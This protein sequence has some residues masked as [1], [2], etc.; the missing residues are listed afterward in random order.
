MLQEE[1]AKVEAAERQAGDRQK[2]G[3]L[4]DSFCER[5]TQ[6]AEDK[7]RCLLCRK[8]FRGPEFVHKHIREKHRDELQAYLASPPPQTSAQPAGAGG[9]TPLLA[10]SPEARRAAGGGSAFIAGRP[11]R[12]QA[13]SQRDLFFDQDV[14]EEVSLLACHQEMDSQRRGFNQMLHDA[15]AAGDLSRMQQCMLQGGWEL[16]QKD[17]D[18][19]TPLHL[20]AQEGHSLCVQYL[21]SNTA[22]VHAVNEAGFTPL[23]GAARQGHTSAGEFLLQGGAVV[24]GIGGAKMLAAL[25]LSATNGHRD[26]C[27]AL[28]L[29]RANVNLQDSNGE[30]ALHNAARFGDRAL[31]EVILSW[32]A[33]TTITDN[34]GWCALHEAARWGDGELV[35]IFL[36]RGADAFARS[37]E[38]E[39]PLH[40]V[41]GGYA[42]LEVVEVLLAWRSDIN[43]RDY[44]GETPLHVAVRL[45]DTDFAGVLLSRS[46]DVNA[47]NHAG[48]TPLDFAKRDD[49]RWLLRSHKAKKG[50]GAG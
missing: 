6:Q 48:A 45:G 26:M 1:E 47:S 37:T 7:F 46:A 33:D 27:K 10:I 21:L 31:C 5:H 28:L 25:H 34:D 8:M 17:A 18:G 24:N 29:H 14:A 49:I 36:E 20:C 15:A 12:G 4:E 13:K 38:G 2:V 40:V 16:S 23:H 9:S 32:G 41:P 3:S 39:T 42:E 11:P 35:S 19:M 43:V 44:T 50:T 30:S 22:N